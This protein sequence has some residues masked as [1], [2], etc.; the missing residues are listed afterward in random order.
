MQWPF[1]QV[2]WYG[3]HTGVGRVATSY[4]TIDIAISNRNKHI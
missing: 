4:N 2:N 1:A 3:E